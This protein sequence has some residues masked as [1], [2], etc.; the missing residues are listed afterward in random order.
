MKQNHEID[1]ETVDVVSSQLEEKFEA[2]AT[3]AELSDFEKLLVLKNLTSRIENS[4][5]VKM[6]A[7]AM[8]SVLTK[9]GR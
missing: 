9:I 6:Q 3:S 7:A 1:Q 8:F 2:F 4:M 5:A